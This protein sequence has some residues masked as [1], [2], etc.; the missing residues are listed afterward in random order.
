[1]A[2]NFVF[3]KKSLADLDNLGA[4]EARRIIKKIKWLGSLANPLSHAKFLVDS[5]VGDIRFRIGDYRAIAILSEQTIVIV[6]I[7]HRREIYK[8]R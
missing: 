6:A 3:S 2:Y 7:G 5:S 4:N 1:M 8:R